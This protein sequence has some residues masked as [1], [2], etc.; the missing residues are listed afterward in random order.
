[1]KDCLSTVLLLALLL[2]CPAVAVPAQQMQE[3]ASVAKTGF[4]AEV[5]KRIDEAG[6][7]LVELAKAIPQEKYSWRPVG[8]V[9]S[10]G[11]VY[12]HVA[13]ANFALP[14]A[15]GILPPVGIEGELEK[16]TDKAEVVKHLQE[17][18]DYVRQIIRDTPDA[19]LDKT[20]KLYGK[21]TTVRDVFLALV[22]HAHEHLGQSVAYGR[23]N[24]IT[25]PWAAQRSNQA[26]R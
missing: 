3:K 11:E 20:V 10:V 23:M 8:E 5:L 2:A 4:R 9:Y 19:E 22:L 13:I 25:P 18:F 26:R 6:G 7:K 12:T 21:E 16:I 1:M 17:S 15:L 24:K 14:R